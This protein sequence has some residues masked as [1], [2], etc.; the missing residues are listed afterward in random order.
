M[1]RFLDRAK[2]TVAK[3]QP[4]LTLEAIAESLDSTARVVESVVAAAGERVAD[5][6]RG[7]DGAIRELRVS[8]NPL[9]RQ[10]EVVTA[11][12]SWRTKHTA[13][14]AVVLAL[15]LAA[16]VALAWRA[17]ALAQST[18]DVL[19]QILENQAKAQAAKGGTRR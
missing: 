6:Q 16:G 13:A 14:W 17:H 1:L 18:H 11:W 5:L 3:R 7:Q 2:R 4:E 8:V 10:A 12:R 15:A 9:G 19:Q